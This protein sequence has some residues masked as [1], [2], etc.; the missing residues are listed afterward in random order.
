M[1]MRLVHIFLINVIVVR[2]AMAQEANQ[3]EASD[4]RQDHPIE[5]T[6]Q[7]AQPPNVTV[8]SP[9][10]PDVTIQ[11]PAESAWWRVTEILVTLTGIG[12]AASMIVW[13]LNRQ[14]NSSLA[15]QEETFRK[16]LRAELYESLQKSISDANSAVASASTFARLVPISLVN[17]REQ[18]RL[19]LVSATSGPAVRERA[20]KFAEL[21]YAVSNSVVD[22]IFIFESYAIAV[23]EF[24]VFQHALNSA[25]YDSGEAFGPLHS[26]LIRFLPTDLSSASSDPALNPYVHHYVPPPPNDDEIAAIQDLC[27]TYIKAVDDIGC[28]VFDLQVEAQNL[29]L[30]DLYPDQKAHLRE[31]IDPT[32]K[33]VTSEKSDE[34]IHYF[35]EETPWGRSN[36][37]TDASVRESLSDSSNASGD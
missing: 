26:E 34:L 10:A 37:A 7:P 30:G 16:N 23:P 24:Q 8:Q 9:P 32:Y 25:L 12:I 1:V 33:V 29:L 17:Y 3:D 35:R 6:V 18:A 5:I 15:V 21:H 20:P 19:G 36:R 22:L 2:S 11:F 13:Q 4:G 31:P 28:Y 14:H 27:E